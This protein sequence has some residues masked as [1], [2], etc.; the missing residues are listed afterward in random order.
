[1]NQLQY[2]ICL[3][4]QNKDCKNNADV[5]DYINGLYFDHVPRKAIDIAIRDL[6]RRGKIVKKKGLRIP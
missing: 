6:K 2:D 1:M 3:V 5:Y 4:I